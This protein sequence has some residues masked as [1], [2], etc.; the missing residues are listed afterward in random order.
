MTERR[1]PV[2]RVDCPNCHAAYKVVR[3]EGA[4]HP[5]IEVTCTSCGALLPPREGKYMLK[6]FLVERPRARKRRYP[7]KV[8]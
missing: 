6:Y 7:P 3:V 1:F 5:D 8:N 4:S 2:P